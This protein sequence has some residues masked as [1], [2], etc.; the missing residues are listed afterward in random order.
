MDKPKGEFD[1]QKK[2]AIEGELFAQLQLEFGRFENTARMYTQH[3]FIVNA[4]GSAATLA[5]LGTK[6]G[7]TFAIWPLPFFIFGVI[8]CGAKL[9]AEFYLN[10]GTFNDALNRRNKFS[11]TNEIEG[12][13]PKEEEM[14]KRTSYR[15]AHWA[16][17]I[18][19]GLF[20]AGVISGWVAYWYS[21]PTPELTGT[22]NH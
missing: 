12:L 13:Y 19:H 7:S 9:L 5:F 20:I 3:I 10:R 17:F 14:K 6:T 4:G 21:L 16:S 1:P 8:A 2:R 18:A 11:E 22:E 15:I